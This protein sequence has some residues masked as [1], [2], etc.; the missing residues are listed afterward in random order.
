MLYEFKCKEC[1]E[2][3]EE[4]RTLKENTNTS[5]CP[6]CQKKAD[7]IMSMFGFKIVGFAAINGYSHANK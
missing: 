1:G 5:I 6:K 2:E 7:K 4:Y 3:F